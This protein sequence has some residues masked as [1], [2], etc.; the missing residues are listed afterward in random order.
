M[1][2]AVFIQEYQ[3]RILQD[4]GPYISDEFKKFA[5]DFRSVVKEEAQLAGAVLQKFS[6]GHY[7]VSGFLA[8]EGKYVYFSYNL[9]RH[10]PIDLSRDDAMQGIL[11]R[12]AKDAKD[13]RGYRNHF[14]NICYFADAVKELFSENV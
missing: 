3:G 12:R 14:A 10:L 4:G 8:K 6:V 5:K 1:K 9:P 7:D 11:I 2:K 13:F